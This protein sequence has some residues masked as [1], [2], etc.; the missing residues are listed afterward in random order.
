MLLHVDEEVECE[1]KVLGTSNEF[2][3]RVPSCRNRSNHEKWFD[4]DSITA[5]FEVS[6]KCRA[7]ENPLS[8]VSEL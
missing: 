1:A 5:R 8:E 4:F 6:A 7:V 2:C 3:S